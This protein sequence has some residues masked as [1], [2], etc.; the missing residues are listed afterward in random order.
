[1]LYPASQSDTTLSERIEEALRYGGKSRGAVAEHLGISANTLTRYSQGTREI[2]MANAA[3]LMKFLH[4]EPKL[5]FEQQPIFRALTGIKSIDTM[6][7]EI[8]EAMSVADENTEDPVAHYYSPDYTCNSDLYEHYQRQG[9]TVFG[10]HPQASIL[11]RGGDPN[12]EDGNQPGSFLMEWIEDREAGP[13]YGVKREN[14]WASLCNRSA[15]TGHRAEPRLIQANLITPTMIS[16]ILECHW[17][18][19]P[20]LTEVDP[21][22][23]E[24]TKW[25]TVDH[26]ELTNTIGSIKSCQG[27]LKIARKTWSP[28]LGERGGVWSNTVLIEAFGDKPRRYQNGS[29]PAKLR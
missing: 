7:F 10:K 27:E 11:A 6:L 18:K 1:M 14:E 9:T 8:T 4:L 22:W 29:S 2:S 19:P 21:P 5:L 15:S 16:M 26:I 25:Q 12:A 13:M 17:L 3:K 20:P 28:L 23:V 24:K